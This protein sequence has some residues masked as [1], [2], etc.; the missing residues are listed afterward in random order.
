MFVAFWTR[1]EACIKASGLGLSFTLASF[2]VS[3]NARE[4]RVI[5]SGGDAAQSVR[6]WTLVD[7]ETVPGCAAACAVEGMG[8]SVICREFR[9]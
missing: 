5:V 4:P 9:L 6:S 8:L 2:D 3:G 7:V 1:K